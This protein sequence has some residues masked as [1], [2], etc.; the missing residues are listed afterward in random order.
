VLIQDFQNYIWNNDQLPYDKEIEELLRDL[1]YDLDF[2]DTDD[3]IDKEIELTLQKIQK[4]GSIRKE[5]FE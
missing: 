3:C 5:N 4:L 1:T 2:C